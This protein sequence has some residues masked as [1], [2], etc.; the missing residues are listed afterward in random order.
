MFL[1]IS[2]SRIVS[3]WYIIE[4][5]LS[6]QQSSIHTKH[7]NGTLFFTWKKNSE[8]LLLKRDTIPQNWTRL[9]STEY[10][11]NDFL[12]WDSI[13]ITVRVSNDPNDPKDDIHLLYNGTLLNIDFNYVYA[14][15]H[16]IRPRENVE[17]ERSQKD[18]VYF[19]I[20]R[21]NNELSFCKIYH[22]TNRVT[23]DIIKAIVDNF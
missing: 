19:L 13:D 2:K 22:S 3:V 8:F 10:A 12:L 4:I 17:K 18:S 5:F 21:F 7:I 9:N 20:E 6:A 23:K 11:V 15:F 14:L 1:C 16:I